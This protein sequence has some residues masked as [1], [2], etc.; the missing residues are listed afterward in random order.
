MKAG[1][2]EGAFSTFTAASVAPSV[3]PDGTNTGYLHAPGYPGSLTD[4]TGTTVTSNT[5]YNYVHFPG[6]LGVGTSL[7][8]VTNVTFNGCLFD[9]DGGVGNALTTLYGDGIKFSYCTFAPQGITPYGPPGGVTLAQSYQ[10]AIC[11][12]GA[13]STTVQQL[14]VDRCD[15]WGFG[16]AI[17]GD[18]STQAKPQVFTNN[19]IHDACQDTTYHTDGI[20]SPSGGSSSY[21]VITG[22]TINSIGDTQ[23][24][25]YQNS[26]GP[27]TWDH[28]TI[29]GNQ[30][31]GFG[32]TVNVDAGTTGSPSPPTNCTFTGNTFTTA[33]LPSF[34]PLRDSGIA[35]G[36]GNTWSGNKWL[37]PDGAQWGHAIYNGYFWLPQVVTNASPTLDELSA[38]LVSLTDF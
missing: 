13:F 30:L 3:F 9:G 26:P 21:V 18:G 8:H 16:N 20:G 22:N 32:F 4:G 37:V 2:A 17:V 24:I 23:A 5:T 19:F 36:A 38:G 33:L 29:T 7:S 15:V 14:T 28:F 31:G 6:G 25:A 27:G 1:D 34:G 10:Y 12:N 11:F 35:T